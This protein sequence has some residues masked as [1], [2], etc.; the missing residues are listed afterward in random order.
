M[1][2]PVHLSLHGAGAIASG[3]FAKGLT[4]IKTGLTLSALAGELERQKATKVDA[5]ARQDGLRLELTEQPEG[6]FPQLYIPTNDFRQPVRP[7]AHGQIASRLGIPKQYYDRMLR[8]QPDLLVKN[9]NTWFAESNERRMVRSLDGNVRAFLSD[10][11]QRIE[12]FEVAEVALGVLLGDLGGDCQVVSCEVTES[13]LYIKAV[14]PKIR[15][16]VAKVGDTIQA[17]VMIRNSEIGLGAFD[18]SAFAEVLACTNGMVIPDS[19]FRRSHVGA[20]A[21]E[22]DAYIL[23]DDTKKAD[24][25]AIMLKARDYIRAACSEAEFA[26][27]VE[28][29]RDAAGR[30]LQGDPSKA[31]EILAQR[32]GLNET[33]RGGVMRHL[34]AGGDI[35]QW[36]LI[37]AVTRTAQDCE[38]YDRATDLETLGGAMIDLNRDQWRELAE[39]A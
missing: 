13:R 31:V 38:S 39:A 33:E 5:I 4:Q 16:D 8:E 23:A 37:N 29:M 1:P 15:Q 22:G 25:T 28:K 20:R 11:Y 7:I 27:R 32:N 14:F 26:R 3:R 36:G 21:D 19:R 2:K 18:V 12:N 34:I 10:K 30:K 35:S 17:G 9:V 24:D 6:T